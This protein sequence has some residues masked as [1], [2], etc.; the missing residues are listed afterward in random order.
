MQPWCRPLCIDMC[1]IRVKTRVSARNLGVPHCLLT[2]TSRNVDHGRSYCRWV[3]WSLSIDRFAVF[4]RNGLAKGN[5][6]PPVDT[7]F[8]TSFIARYSRCF[9]GRY[10][11]EI[12]I[13][14]L[15]NAYTHREA[16]YVEFI[17]LCVPLGTRYCTLKRNLS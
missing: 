5:T 3:S 2:A 4:L 12:V 10:E 7:S 8:V 17:E 11:E 1:V 6:H 16:K 9:D 14:L 15:H 13:A